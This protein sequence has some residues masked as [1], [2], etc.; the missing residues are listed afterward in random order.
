[1]RY[2]RSQ[3]RNRRMQRDEIDARL[4]TELTNL[5]GSQNTGTTNDIVLTTDTLKRTPKF[6]CTLAHG[7]SIVF[8][9]GFKNLSELYY[10][11]GTAFNISPNDIL[12]CTANNRKIEPTSFI[13]NNVNIGDIIYAHVKGQRKE[14]QMTKTGDALGITITDNGAGY[15]FVKKIKPGSTSALASPAISIGDHIEKI[16][17]N[18]MVGMTHCNVARVLRNIAVGETFV[19][20]LI[21]PYKT[22]FSHI[23][24]RSSR[25]PTKT[26][27]DI[28]SGTGTL[29]FKANGEAVLQEA[30]D[31]MIIS[32]M[33]DVFDSYLGLHDDE[34][35][36]SIWEIGRDCQDAIELTNKIKESEMNDFQFPEELIFDMWGVIDDFK[37]ERLSTKSD[38]AN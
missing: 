21:E 2:S 29:R 34:L 22:G 15:C 17:G 26:T 14:V 38:K 4:S 10:N 25:I 7:S 20:R 6:E 12:Y 11:I 37:N 8:V 31:Q 3:S 35:A 1:M 28:T 32:A 27:N 16:N 5:F 13:T 33:N 24:S 18:S 30:P 9:S 36:L 19:I 23:S